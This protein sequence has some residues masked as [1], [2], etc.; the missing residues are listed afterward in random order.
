[1]K[2]DGV[3]SM[4]IG[5]MH[6]STRA[7]GPGMDRFGMDRF[8]ADGALADRLA[9]S[10]RG[11]PSRGLARFMRRACEAFL[12]TERNEGLDHFEDRRMLTVTATNPVNDFLVFQNSQPTTI[13]VD[14][15]F[16]DDAISGQVVQ[17]QSVLGDIFVELFQSSRPITT[18]NFLRYADNDLYD[19]TVIHRSVPGF[20]IQGGG[21]EFPGLDAIDTFDPIQNEPGISNT[22]G[23][24]AMAKLGGDPNSATSQWF[25][26]LANNAGNLDNQ[27]GGFTVFGRVLGNGMAVADAIA[28]LPTEDLGGAFNEI[29]LRNYTGGDPT[30]DNVVL[31]QTI[32][33]VGELTFT[34]TSSNGTLVA[35]QIIIVDGQARLQLT[36]GSGT[37]EAN[38]TIR[39]ESRSGDFVEDTFNVRV[40]DQQLAS[41]TVGQITVTPDFVPNPGPSTLVT[42]NALNVTDNDGT[43]SLVEFYRDNGDGVFNADT[44]TLLGTSSDASINYRI[45]APTVAGAASVRYFARARDN[46]F[47]FSTAVTVANTQNTPPTIG[48]FTVTSASVTRPSSLGLEVR[49][50]SDSSGVS[51][52]EFWRDINANGTLEP[53]VDVNLG[54]AINIAGKY[55]ITIQTET[56]PAGTIPFLAVAYDPQGLTGLNT[57]SVQV[58]NYVPTFSGIAG[59]T[60]VAVRGLTAEMSILWP[61]DRDGTLQG[62]EYWLDVNGNSVIDESIDTLVARGDDSANNFRGRFST[63][64]FNLG[65]ST[66]MV[67]VVDDDNA[68]SAVQAIGFRV[69][70][71]P[72]IASVELASNTVVTNGTVT[73][74]ALNVSDPDGILNGVEIFWDRDE[75]GTLNTQLFDRLIGRAN[76]VGTNWIFMFYASILYDNFTNRLFVQ[77][78]DSEGARGPATPIQ[79]QI[80]RP[81][82]TSPAQ[83]PYDPSE[84]RL[85]DGT[86]IT[87]QPQPRGVS[88]SVR[89]VWTNT[90]AAM[91]AT[92]EDTNTL[93][94]SVEF[95]VIASSLTP[96]QAESTRGS[97]INGSFAAGASSL[98]YLFPWMRT[99]SLLSARR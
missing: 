39:A 11:T 32:T 79:V 78:I 68:S 16:D 52:V 58:I 38:V 30:A 62:A 13:R 60:Q 5:V 98:V 3:T 66:I 20:V 73:V 94:S 86:L 26:N 44:D 53:D 55:R 9:G 28:A 31:F 93:A 17:F 29:P 82:G 1:M 59:E 51:R 70:R 96:F 35:P 48:T 43:V 41:P 37:G 22:R 76:K 87:Q 81:G 88:G 46:D 27:N 90:A 49:N 97:S 14:D 45:T 7:N 54:S 50:V 57:A 84:F 65:V 80:V 69:N 61:R 99:T 2:Y 63:A 4:E 40:V 74:R 85:P 95:P 18:T 72:Q 8:G 23:T 67:R 12:G 47:L 25:F 10:P 75:S 15:R 42:L 24:I 64:Q 92:S 36:Y 19:N 6:R 77:A 71:A 91:A 21:F 89:R 34:V 33:R 83:N 56:L